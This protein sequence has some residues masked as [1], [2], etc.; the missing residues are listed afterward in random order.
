MKRKQFTSSGRPCHILVH[1]RRLW[2]LGG[3]AAHLV[4]ESRVAVAGD[5]RNLHDHDHHTGQAVAA[6]NRDT[7]Q[8]VLHAVREVVQED[9]RPSVGAAGSGIGGHDHRSSRDAGYG[10]DN[11]HTEDRL[12]EDCS[13]G[14]AVRGGHNHHMVAYKDGGLANA[15]GLGLAGAA[16]PE[17]M[18]C[19]SQ[20]FPNLLAY[21]SH[22]QHTAQRLP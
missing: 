1:I 12:V 7:G 15:I 13:A 8:N 21:N 19:V 3:M 16:L 9:S 14:Q 17:S 6:G 2:D 22:L 11:L 18:A 5:G 4:E 10:L 20:K